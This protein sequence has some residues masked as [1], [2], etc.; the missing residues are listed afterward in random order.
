[1][2]NNILK[3][4]N[5]YKAYRDLVIKSKEDINICTLHRPVMILIDT[6]KNNHLVRGHRWVQLLQLGTKHII[7]TSILRSKMSSQLIPKIKAEMLYG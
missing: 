2:S 3:I 4:G 5:Y 7:P 6:P 1:M